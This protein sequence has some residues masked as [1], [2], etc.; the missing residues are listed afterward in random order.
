[1]AA[2]KSTECCHQRGLKD[3]KEERETENKKCL[4]VTA[5]KRST[6]KGR[7]EVMIGRIMSDR[8]SVGG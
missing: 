8:R 5:S 2:K 4:E 6:R 7:R 1:M 3:V